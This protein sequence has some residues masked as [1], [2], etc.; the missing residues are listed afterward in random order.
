[1][2]A[3]ATDRP[4]EE[5][6]PVR[7]DETP[8][9][10]INAVL[11]AEDHRFFEHGGVDA[12]ALLRAAWAN[13]RAGR[14]KQGG[15]TITQQLVKNR[16]LS[17]QRTLTRKLREA[18]LAALVECALLEGADPRGL[19]ERDLSRAAR[20]DRDPRR[21]RGVARVLRQGGPPARRRPRRRCSPAMIRGPN[22]LL[23]GRQPGAGA[24]A[25]QHRARA[26]ARAGNDQPEAN[27][28]AR[29]AQPVQVRSLVSTGQS[30]PY[31]VDYVRQRARAALRHERVARCAALVSTPRSISA[32]SAS[33]RR[34][35]RAASIGSRPS[36]PRLAATSRRGCRPRCVALDPATGEIRALVGG[37]DYQAS[38][39]NRATLG[40]PPAG[41]GVQAVRLS[42]RARAR[43]D[44]APALH[45]GLA[46]SRTR[47][48]R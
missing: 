23:A 12:R 9:V 21:R 26:D 22:M 18:W 44:G 43:G 27:S 39:F 11:A 30:A 48:S 34:R 41:L 32:C 10:L 40:A 15:S 33:P 42:G 46:A 3:S 47:R 16:L 35:W 6:K 5:H 19:P 13:L 37:R 25:P 31:F 4:G 45:R 8:K 14:V 24:R 28:S 29:A 20:A 1:M 2:L 7:L 36:C 17:P 38:Q